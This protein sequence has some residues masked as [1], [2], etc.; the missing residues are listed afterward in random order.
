MP[1]NFDDHRRRD[2][3]PCRRDHHDNKYD[4]YHDDHKNRC[5]HRKDRLDNPIWPW[6]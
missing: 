2:C 6:R 3:P 5:S 4:D 1:N